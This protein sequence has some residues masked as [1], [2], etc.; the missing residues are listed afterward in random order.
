MVI[1]IEM[2][3]ILRKLAKWQSERPLVTVMMMK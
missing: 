2:C 1:L 3:G